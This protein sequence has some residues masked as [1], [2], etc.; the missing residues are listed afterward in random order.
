MSQ[1]DPLH[2]DMELRIAEA[3]TGEHPLDDALRQHLRA[4][5]ACATLERAFAQLASDAAEAPPPGYWASFDARLKARRDAGDA[6]APS[7]LA[8]P[9]PRAPAASRASR[10]KRWLPLAAAIAALAA[11]GSWWLATRAPITGPGGI[12]T[13]EHAPPEHAPPEH[14]PGGPAAAPDAP[15]PWKAPAALAA[16]SSA[17]L[18]EGLEMLGWTAEWSPVDTPLDAAFDGNGARDLP[19]SAWGDVVGDLA[20]EMSQLDPID[21][22]ALLVALEEAT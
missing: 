18:S 6:P 19:P 2:D 14:A 20:D 8:P 3:L 15:A 13:A 9:A 1:H 21:Q 7:P 5:P 22:Q 12:A 10:S 4:C 17:T 11:G 16:A